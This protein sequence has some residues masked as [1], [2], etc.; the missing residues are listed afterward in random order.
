MI[1]LDYE[2]IEVNKGEFTVKCKGKAGGQRKFLIM[3]IEAVLETFEEEMPDEFA[4]ALDI[5]LKDRG[6]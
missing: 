2:A 3:E 4:N 1:K 5:F 6:V